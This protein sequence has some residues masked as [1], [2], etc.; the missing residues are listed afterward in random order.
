MTLAETRHCKTCKSAGRKWDKVPCV[1][2]L[3]Y[4][5]WKP[6]V[7]LVKPRKSKKS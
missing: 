4:D 7:K 5:E 3:N 2:C 6:A 1:R